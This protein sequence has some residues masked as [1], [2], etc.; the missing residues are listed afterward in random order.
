[1]LIF[2]SSKIGSNPEEGIGSCGCDSAP[3][4]GNTCVEGLRYHSPW[5]KATWDRNP[6]E[7]LQ[8]IISH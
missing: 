1:M 3:D 8:E 4:V 5:C 6:N 2:Y 7:M